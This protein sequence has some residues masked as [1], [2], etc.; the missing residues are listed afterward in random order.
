[1]LT[2]CIKHVIFSFAHSTVRLV[3]IFV[4]FFS[5]LSVASLGKSILSVRLGHFSDRDL[6]KLPVL[7]PG[8]KV[9]EIFQMGQRYKMKEKKK[10]RF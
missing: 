5:L 9:K 7:P 3:R 8:Q 1:M 2:H 6:L 4:F 10:W